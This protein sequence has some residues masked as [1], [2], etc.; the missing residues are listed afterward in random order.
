MFM[1]NFDIAKWRVAYFSDKTSAS[2]L[3]DG[4]DGFFTQGKANP[5]QVIEIA[6][7]NAGTYAGQLAITGLDIYNYLVAMDEKRMSQIWNSENLEYRIKRVY[8]RKFDLMAI[9]N[10]FKIFRNNS[11]CSFNSLTFF[12]FNSDAK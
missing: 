11:K 7:N 6:Q 9:Y 1:K 8:F 10:S 12:T 5:D 4:I 3:L 2:N